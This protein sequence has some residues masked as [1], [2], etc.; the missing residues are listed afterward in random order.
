MLGESALG[1]LAIGDLAD[2]FDT[3]ITI[4][5]TGSLEAVAITAREA[6]LTDTAAVLVYTAEL[7]P[8]VMLT[9][10]I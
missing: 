2:R 8:A 3:Q 7:S 10:R 4:V 1:D 6:A 5:C 9:G